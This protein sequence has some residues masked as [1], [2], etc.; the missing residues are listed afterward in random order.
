VDQNAPDDTFGGATQ[1]R[2]GVYYPSGY[3]IGVIDDHADAQ[4]CIDELVAAGM[5]P[6]DVQLITAEDALGAHGRQRREQGL[7]DRVIGALATNERSIEYE[8]LMQASEGSH[9]VAFRAKDDEQEQAGQQ[10]LEAHGVRGMRH[11]AR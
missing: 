2:H 3:T 10:I 4:A 9:F 11:Y 1:H 7:L 5:D 6:S 8:Y